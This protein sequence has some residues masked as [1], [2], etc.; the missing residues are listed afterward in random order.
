LSLIIPLAEFFLR[1]YK[2]IEGQY[3]IK[4]LKSLERFISSNF[5]NDD[6]LLSSITTKERYESIK[7]ILNKIKRQ[8]IEPDFENQIK[9][10]LSYTEI[11]NDKEKNVL[12]IVLKLIDIFNR[13]DNRENFSSV[14]DQILEL[15]KY[16]NKN[17]KLFDF[18]EIMLKAISKFIFTNENKTEKFIPLLLIPVSYLGCLASLNNNNFQETV[19]P[20]DDE[21]ANENHSLSSDDEIN[22]TRDSDDEEEKNDFE[23]SS[24][25]KNVK[26]DEEKLIFDTIQENLNICDIKL[27]LIIT[28]KLAK[29]F[30][31]PK[32]DLTGTFFEE[33]INSI[34]LL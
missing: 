24:I 10:A 31:D 26:N 14:I 2:E 11:L 22:N 19:L 4:R 23:Q 15:F 30:E 29:E 32:L 9:N 28:E 34:P 5:T 21:N 17:E 3:L 6:D 12:E 25:V 16:S 27:S 13:Q 1:R 20:E 18:I 7:S 8:K 33:I